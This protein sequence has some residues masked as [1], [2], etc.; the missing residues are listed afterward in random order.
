MTLQISFKQMRASDAIKRYASEKSENFAKYFRGRIT[1]T[2]TFSV[3]K[4]LKVA[5]CHLVGNNMDYFGQA[6]TSD[7]YG[8]IDV[9]LEK[10]ERQIRKHKEIVKDHL[11]RNGHRVPLAK[12][13]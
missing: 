2:W 13:S 5:H 10:I 9:V 12:A 11:H 1:V 4:H 8:S 3:D 6:E 7:M